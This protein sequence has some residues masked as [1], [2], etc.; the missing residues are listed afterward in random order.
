MVPF[1]FMLSFLHMMFVIIDTK[2]PLF[3][4]RQKIDHLTAV[5]SLAM[6]VTK[7]L[8][9]FARIISSVNLALLC[10]CSFMFSVGLNH[11]RNNNNNNMSCNI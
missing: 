6:Y 10:C 5:V 2:K 8:F 9:I 4:Q 11:I 1:V 3:S 7:S